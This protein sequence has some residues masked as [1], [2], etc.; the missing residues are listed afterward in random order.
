MRAAACLLIGIG[1]SVQSAAEV[2]TAS[3]WLGDKA[4]CARLLQTYGVGNLRSTETT[5]G[6]EPWCDHTSIESYKYAIIGL[7]SNRQCDYICSSLAGWFAVD[8]RNGAVFEWD[9]NEQ[10]LGKRFDRRDHSRH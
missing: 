1:W 8:R 10:R 5:P 9:I 3:H 7:H 6:A 4:A 2:K